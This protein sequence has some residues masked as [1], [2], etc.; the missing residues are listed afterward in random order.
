MTV[1]VATLCFGLVRI[2][3]GNESG[4]LFIASC[5]VWK[6]EREWHRRGERVGSV[7]ERGEERERRERRAT[8]P[9]HLI[10]YC[11]IVD[12]IQVRYQAL[13]Q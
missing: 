10:I 7:A 11:L 12:P 3:A 13:R 8:Q 4:T 2:S 6:N 9:P 5:Y 1:D